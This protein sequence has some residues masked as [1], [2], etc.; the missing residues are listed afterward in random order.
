M[1]HFP[2]HTLARQDMQF[3]ISFQLYS[4]CLPYIKQKHNSL[5]AQKSR[6]KLNSGNH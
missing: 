4:I 1:V 2:E 6:L 5:K 3:D